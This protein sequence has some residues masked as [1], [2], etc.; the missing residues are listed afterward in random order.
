MGTGDAP[1][2]TLWRSL[3]IP[4]VALLIVLLVVVGMVAPVG[5]VDLW[6]DPLNGDDAH[7]GTSP[8]DALRTFTAAWDQI[9]SGSSLQTGY[10]IRLV[11]GVYSEEA[12][13]SGG[14]LD[15]RHGTALAPIVIEG[16]GGEVTLPA[17][18]L[19]DCHHLVLRNLTL[20]GGAGGGNVLHL[21]A[22]SNI[23]VTRCRLLGEGDVEAYEG[24]QEVLKAN[25]C[26][27]LVIE[28]SEIA[29]A[30]G[31]AL[32]LFAVEGAVIRRNR[33][34]HALDW[35]AY[36][37]GGSASIEFSANELWDG[38]AGGFAAGQGSGFEFLVPPRIHYEASEVRCVNNLI[39]DIEG[40]GLGV[41]GG[42]NV[43]F[44]Y[45][46]LYRVGSAS[47]VIEAGYGQ[48]SC[49]G[50]LESCRRLLSL[51]GWGTLDLDGF[52]GIPNRNVCIQNNLVLNPEGAASAWSHFSVAGPVNPPAGSNVP[53]PA[54]A[55]EGLL[56]SGNVIWNGPAD[57]PLGL[58]A[59]R[60]DPVTVI[61]ENWI[62]TVHPLL[63][64]PGAGDYSVSRASLAGVT[65][66]PLRSF[67]GNDLPVVPAEPQ[68]NLTNTVLTDR[69]GR[70]R[71]DQDLPGALV[72]DDL[73]VVMVPGGMGVPLDL[74]SDGRYEDVNGNG[75]VDFNDVVLYFNQLD[76]ISDHEP[77]AAFDL[78]GDSRVDFNDVVALFHAL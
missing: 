58:E 34:H 16:A 27:D 31:T 51:G 6:V 67:P 24:P 19:H 49:D 54:Y 62:N 43:L 39:H 77:L 23:T 52:E 74:N 20:R 10:R 45:N 47:H 30:F 11:P 59:S 32:D 44:A 7:T 40:A 38:R 73:M 17:L 8:A 33:I 14:W 22:C 60:L 75:S 66:A 61:A 2:L 70:L 46:T 68:G 41:H 3:T 76:W 63:G 53:S 13:P 56:I 15:D 21:A 37:K 35:C 71:A 18:D 29:H 1:L 12:V 65:V 48:R 72:S 64:N 4:E 5:A 36:V 78:N 26:R 69:D 55:D 9:P 50:D 25:Q 28:D 57:H 42:Y